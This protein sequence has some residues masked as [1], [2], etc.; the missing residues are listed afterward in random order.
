MPSFDIAKLNPSVFWTLLRKPHWLQNLIKQQAT[1]SSHADVADWH[2]NIPTVEDDGAHPDE[3]PFYFEWWYFDVICTGGLTISII[4]HL[5]DLIKPACKKGSLNISIS[6]QGKPVFQ[7]FIPYATERIHA[8]PKMCDVR[9]GGNRCAL[10]EG[11][12]KIL[13][14]EAEV[15]ADLI[16]EPAT[17]GWRP[18]SGKFQFGH[19]NAFFSWVVPQ[20]RAHAKGTIVINGQEK[21]VE[22]VGYHDHNWG[23]VS[24]LDTI[25]EWSWGRVYLG[26]YSCVFADIQLSA[27]YGS[28]RVMPF[29]FF[30]GDEILISGFLQ[31]SR[32]LD[33]SSD[34]LRNPVS[35]DVP[36]GWQL[37]WDEQKNNMK[38]DL[39]LETSSVLEKADLLSGNIIRQ[40]IIENLLAHPYYIRCSVTAKGEWTE[41][42]RS[43]VLDGK[44]IFEQIT[45]GR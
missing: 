38:F 5:T 43:I 9:M 14:E 10:E 12:Y 40:K 17:V 37:C 35:T 7:R 26:D 8:S 6:E 30:H 4:L 3:S 24:L 33:E 34:F 41:Q 20:P 1:W 32:P 22:G 29:S 27:R 18:G 23:T 44:G 11:V 19:E 42:K 2:R 28:G 36:R 39:I 13:I 16:F 25:K 31:G 45:F 21:A 15:R